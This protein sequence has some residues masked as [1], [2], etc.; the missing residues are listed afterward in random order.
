MQGGEYIIMLKF[1]VLFLAFSLV[2]FLRKYLIPVAIGIAIAFTLDPFVSTLEK[3]C[4]FK[5]LVAILVAYLLMLAF[6]LFL[7]Y[8][9]ADLISGQISNKSFS[10]AID[11]LFEYYQNHKEIIEKLFP[12][13]Q[14]DADYGIIVKTIGKA[15]Y[16]I[17]VGLILGVY[18][19]KDKK[20]FSMLLARICHLFLP[21][22]IHGYVSELAF[23]IKEV[24][25]SF[26]RGISI[27]SSIVA[28]LASFSLTIIKV[29]YAVLLGIFVG[30]ANVIPYFGPIIG[31]I[32]V[33]IVSYTEIGLKK[34]LIAGLS[35][36]L[37][38]QLECNVIY[39]RIIGNSTGLHPVF[40]LICV[41]I[42]GSLGGI[43]WMV[44]AVPLAGIA[45]VLI[46]KWAEMQ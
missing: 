45:R 27:D 30:I 40:V 15:M 3:K 8:S 31:I 33:A 6:F 35:L 25:A 1:F 24:L 29:P 17:L 42:S 21:Q 26:L 18:F 23:D 37:I 11:T 41:S 22:K 13:F 5:R 46:L 28:L 2:F 38:Q 12:S 10:H 9:M 36:V 32:P 20:Y 44:L 34:T 19:L 4:H 16:S 43:L 7:S 39:P 14:T